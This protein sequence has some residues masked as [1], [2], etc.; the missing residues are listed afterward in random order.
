MPTKEKTVVKKAERLAAQYNLAINLFWTLL[1]LVPAAYYFYLYLPLAR[2]W[3]IVPVALL[4]Y[5]LPAVLIDRLSVRKSRRWYQRVGVHVVL[6][7]VQQGRRINRM[8]QRRY[9]NYRIVYDKTTI[10]RKINETYMFERFHI[11]LL[12]A[13]FIMTGHALVKESWHWGIVLL[14]RKLI[15]NIYSIMLRQYVWLR[16]KRLLQ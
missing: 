4:P 3:I 7:Y 14:L 5:F 2:L 11:G 1:N 8:I 16:L 10:R 13:F 6:G 12:M 15:Y 9:P